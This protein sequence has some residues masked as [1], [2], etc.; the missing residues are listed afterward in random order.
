MSS[1]VLG[2]GFCASQNQ[3]EGTELRLLL[4][5]RAVNEG[6]GSRR[7]A[8]EFPAQCTSLNKPGQDSQ[9]EICSRITGVIW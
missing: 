2:T 7:E 6:A 5:H 1:P 8:G 3:C 4:E 9:E